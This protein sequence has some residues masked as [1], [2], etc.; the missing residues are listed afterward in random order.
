LARALSFDEKIRQ[1]VALLWY[2]LR[3]DEIFY[4]QAA[5]QRTIEASPAFMEYGLAKKIAGWAHAN[6][7]QGGGLKAFLH[8]AAQNSEIVLKI[9]DQK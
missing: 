8:G 1:N 4:L 9:Q 7:E 2:G 6:R 3:N 5:I